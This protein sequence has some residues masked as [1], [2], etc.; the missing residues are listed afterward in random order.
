MRSALPFGAVLLVLA[1]CT[2]PAPSEPA[3]GSPLL[4][5]GEEVVCANPS[6]GFDRLTD[7][8]ASRGFDFDLPA[9]QGLDHL[10][11]G[12]VVST[13]LDGDGDIDILVGQRE[14]PPEGSPQGL[15]YPT[16]P[17]IFANDGAGYFSEVPGPDIDKDY[18][19]DTP[20]T[21]FLAVDLDGDRLPEV[22]QTGPAWAGIAQNLG[23]LQWGPM[24]PIFVPDGEPEPMINTAAFGD[25]DGDGDL[26]LI[27]PA[28]HSVFS[29]EGPKQGSQNV[30]LPDA[31]PH[32][33]YRNDDGVLNGIA[34]LEPYGRPNYSQMAIFTDRDSDGDQDLF[35]VS[36]FGGLPGADPS[37]FFRNDGPAEDGVPLLIN[38]APQSGTNISVGGMG[39]D[40]ADL[41]RDGTLDYC[42]AQFGPLVCLLSDGDGAWFEGTLSLGLAVE[43]N[44]GEPG[45]PNWS[46]YSLDFVDLE[47]DGDL[48][49]AV[50][51]G[52]PAPDDISGLH[53]DRIFEQ[54]EDG[55]FVD[56]SEALGWDDPRRHFGL[57][58]ADYDGDGSLDLFASATEGRHVLWM[59]QCTEGAWIEVDLVGPS[60]NR[61]GHGAQVRVEAGGQ[62]QVREQFN[63]RSLG[64]GPARIH[65]GLG[66][67]E[68]VDRLE[69]LWA[70][71]EQAVF[72]DLPVRR[73]FKVQS[74]H[75]L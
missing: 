73:R 53:V 60:G 55:T 72:D 38:D 50:V 71:G 10:T 61:E 45:Y 7:E 62:V 59:N 67:A 25:M 26:D 42:I 30:E 1:G 18:L 52:N 19:P 20:P 46:A 9:Y 75:G 15:P 51:A 36:E 31:H 65:F 29:G 13:D 11:S 66:G 40:S 22:V 33:L 16:F 32:L 68:R 74:E 48:D 39:I 41:N 8:A 44:F 2:E 4:E 69:V 27:L 17:R 34:E 14:R 70:H 63:L 35:L 24:Q 5:W 12:G 43:A 23:G 64:Q 28:V 56:R 21:A 57:G 58:V 37:A 6:A 47:N 3:G 49:L 54:V